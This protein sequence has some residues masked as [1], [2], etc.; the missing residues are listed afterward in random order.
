MKNPSEFSI[1][2]V[3]PNYN[4]QKYIEKCVE[5]IFEQSYSEI[6]QVIIV[7]DCSTDKSIQVIK[8]LI[9]KYPKLRLVQNEE[10]SGV[11]NTRNIGLN[12]V[13]T[14][15]VTF[16]DA[17]DY[18]FNEDKLKNEMELLIKY[19]KEFGKDILSYSS[20][21]NVQNDLSQ[22]SYPPSNKKSY[23][24]GNVRVCLLKGRNFKTIMRDY[25]ISTQVLRSVGGYNT[26]RNLFEDWELLLKLSR[27]VEFYCTFEYGTAYRC[28]INGLSKRPVSYLK[29]TK[30]KIFYEQ[31]NDISRGLKGKIILEK[32]LIDTK[33][34]TMKKYYKIKKTIKNVLIKSGMYRSNEKKKFQSK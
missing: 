8:E 11:S 10:N 34:T 2:V 12:Y 30:N 19:R 22:F 25:C 31:I 23:L 7:D 17:D 9:E 3:I 27:E 20:V 33:F 1:S 16:I 13:Q 5:S 24:Q 14:K 28:S 26:E 32:L 4:N 15:Y 21:V 29:E 18:Y 6:Y